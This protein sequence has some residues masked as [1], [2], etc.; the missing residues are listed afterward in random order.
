MVSTHIGGD[1]HI[2]GIEVEVPV[3]F[4]AVAIVCL[5]WLTEWLCLF[6]VAVKKLLNNLVEGCQVERDEK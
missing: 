3:I 6:L 2:N 5:K 1:R 4:K